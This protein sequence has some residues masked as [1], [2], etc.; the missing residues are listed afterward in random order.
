MKEVIKFV[1]ERREPDGAW[2]YAFDVVDGITLEILKRWSKDWYKNL[3]RKQKARVQKYCPRGVDRRTA[4]AKLTMAV[5]YA[6]EVTA[7]DTLAKSA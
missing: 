3:S 1:G 4:H 5:G 2:T 7:K 6:V